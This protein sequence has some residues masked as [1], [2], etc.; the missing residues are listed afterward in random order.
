[1]TPLEQ[2]LQNHKTFIVTKENCVYCRHAKELFKKKGQEYH[3]IDYMKNIELVQEIM[4]IKEYMTFPM[5]YLDGHFIGG[6]DNLVKHYNK[7]E[8]VENK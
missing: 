2:E 7:I 8:N 6:Y 1:M 4:N 3:E 5:I